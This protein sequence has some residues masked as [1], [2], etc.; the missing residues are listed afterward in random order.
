M[1]ERR[2]EK[3]IST[4]SKITSTPKTIKSKKVKQAATSFNTPLTRPEGHINNIY[5]YNSFHSGWASEQNE[6]PLIRA[7]TA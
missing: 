3:R 1:Q 6:L 5:K 7:K 4:F 2:E